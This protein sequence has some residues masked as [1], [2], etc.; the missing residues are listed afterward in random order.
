MFVRT[1]NEEDEK[2]VEMMILPVRFSYRFLLDC[3]NLKLA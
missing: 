2:T 1:K 3:L